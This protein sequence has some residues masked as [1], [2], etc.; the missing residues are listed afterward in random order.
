MGI[1]SFIEWILATLSTVIAFVKSLLETKKLVDETIAPDLKGEEKAKA[2]ANKQELAQSFVALA[3]IEAAYNIARGVV[4]A[5]LFGL[6][7]HY[8]YKFMELMKPRPKA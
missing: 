7:L 3:G 8:V 1:W 6:L 5:L 2:I 4:T